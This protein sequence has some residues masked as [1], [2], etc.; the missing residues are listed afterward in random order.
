M[1]QVHKPPLLTLASLI[2]Y[3]SDLSHIHS[4]THEDPSHS[5]SSSPQPAH[6]P[7]GTNM[8]AAEFEYWLYAAEIIIDLASLLGNVVAYFVH[9]EPPLL[10][11]VYN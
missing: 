7:Y 9:V 5:C 10:L 8:N 2:N 3:D 6:L 11:H 4:P 1:I